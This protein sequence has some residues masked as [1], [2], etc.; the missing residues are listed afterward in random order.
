MGF[1]VVKDPQRSAPAR[2][3]E[4][5][6]NVDDIEQMREVNTS[7]GLVVFVYQTQSKHEVVNTNAAAIALAIHEI[8][9]GNLPFLRI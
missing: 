9:T 3:E 4:V 6:I 1:L 7:E 5:W 2:S 8:R